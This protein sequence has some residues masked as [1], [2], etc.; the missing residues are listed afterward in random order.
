MKISLGAKYFLF[1]WQR[2]KDLRSLVGLAFDGNIPVVNENDVLCDPQAQ[3][4]TA[5]LPG[6]SLV[7]AVESLE[8]PVE[9][10]RRYSD[11]VVADADTDCPVLPE[12][13]DFDTPGLSGVFYGVIKQVH[14]DLLY[15]V[16]VGRKVRQI[17][18]DN[19]LELVPVS[20]GALALHHLVDDFREIEL[21]QDEVE[22]ASG[23][24]AG[25]VEQVADEPDET[26]A[27]CVD[28][29]IEL[30]LSVAVVVAIGVVQ[31]GADEALDRGEGSAELCTW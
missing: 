6:T 4:R 19:D 8:D 11:A 15:L 17:V 28:D 9:V 31:E 10:L 16:A 13:R 18:L 27:L 26:V 22:G 21:T 7:D 24:N 5:E 2:N 12:Q 23:L 20:V 14:E 3:S 25:E 29:V 30:H 1:S